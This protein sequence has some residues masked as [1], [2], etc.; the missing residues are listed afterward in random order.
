[1]K[2]DEN[3]AKEIARLREIYERK[4][5]A[6]RQAEHQLRDYVLE[7]MR[8]AGMMDHSADVME[9]IEHMPK[10]YLQFTLY[11]RLFELR[12]AEAQEIEPGA[13]AQNMEQNM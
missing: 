3:T 12:E 8:E 11:E 5:K 9:M 6:A 7:F 4:E 10:G 13:P 1:M 2:I